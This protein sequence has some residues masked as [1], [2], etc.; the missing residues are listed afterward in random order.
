MMEIKVQIA[1]ISTDLIP[2]C[3]TSPLE[4]TSLKYLKLAQQLKQKLK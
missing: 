4:S 2:I 1:Q 3:V